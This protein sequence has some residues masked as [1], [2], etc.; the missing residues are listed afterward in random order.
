MKIHYKNG[1]KLVG[2]KKE[3]SKAFAPE[4]NFAD[5]AALGCSS[6]KET[7]QDTAVLCLVSQCNLVHG[8]SCIIV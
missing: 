6:R 3:A 4:L 7:R 8:Q 1:G 5:D 2:N